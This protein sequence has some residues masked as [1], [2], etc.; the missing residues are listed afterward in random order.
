MISIDFKAKLTLVCGRVARPPSLQ[1][2]QMENLRQQY[3]YWL[4]RKTQQ[5]DNFVKEFNA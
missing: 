4:T 1:D 2:T 3:E 5:I